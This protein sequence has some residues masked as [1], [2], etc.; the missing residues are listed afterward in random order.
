ME[1]CELRTLFYEDNTQL[2]ISVGCQ[3][4][5]IQAKAHMVSIY[6]YQLSCGFDQLRVTLENSCLRFYTLASNLVPCDFK[7]N[8]LIS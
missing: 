1:G 7:A 2:L 6:T 3:S 8:K 4:K 5:E